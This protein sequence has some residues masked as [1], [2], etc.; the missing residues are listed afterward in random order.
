MAV[1]YKII[2]SSQYAQGEEKEMHCN[3]NIYETG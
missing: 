1:K 2:L 3:M